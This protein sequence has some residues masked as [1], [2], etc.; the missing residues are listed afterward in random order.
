MPSHPAGLGAPPRATITARVRD[1]L[2][3]AP[4]TEVYRAALASAL[5]LPGNVLSDTADARWAHLVWVCCQAAGGHPEDAAPT[6]AAVELFMVALDVLDDAEDG[7]ETALHASLGSARSLNVSTG[8]LLLAQCSLLALPAGPMLTGILLDAGMHACAGQH[9]D[10][11]PAAEHGH[12]LDAALDV[13][14]GKSASLVAALCRMGVACAGVDRDVQ[15]RYACF[16]QLLGMALQL[17]N[18]IAAVRPGASGKTDVTLGR[19]TLPLACATYL[20]ATAEAS[21]VADR[22]SPSTEAAALVAWTVAE[23]YRRRAVEMVPALCGGPAG[24]SALMS[25]LRWGVY[26]P[27]ARA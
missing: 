26:D 18:D 12:D 8:L 21:T 16:G 24:R 23:T 4:V 27:G 9:A 17:E 7:E 2:R 10:L 25:L 5:A 6:A 20:D 13:A 22:R 11:A 1:I 14:A 15:E 19:P 3:A